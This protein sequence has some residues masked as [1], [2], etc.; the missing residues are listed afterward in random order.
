MKIERRGKA[1]LAECGAKAISAAIFGNDVHVLDWLIRKEGKHFHA[2]DSTGKTLMH[3]AACF[4]AVNTMKW[5]AIQDAQ[6]R[7]DTKDHDGNT[8]MHLAARHDAPNAMKWLKAQRAL[9]YEKNRDGLTPMH[10][11]AAGNALNALE[12]LRAW[13]N[14]IFAPDFRGHRPMH[15][16]AMNDAVNALNLLHAWADNMVVRKAG[17]IHWTTGSDI[18]MTM[19][20][21][22]EQSLMHMAAKGNAINAMEWLKEHGAGPG[23]MNARDLDENTPL[24]IAAM[25]NAAINNIVHQNGKSTHAMEWLNRYGAEMNARNFKGETPLDCARTFNSADAVEWLEQ[26]GAESG[27]Q[28]PDHRNN[29]DISLSRF[30]SETQYSVRV[31]MMA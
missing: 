17:E 14:N 2:Q 31:P 6:I 29:R 1:L 18:D 20:D 15:H 13:G 5:L 19:V 8:P 26:N 21:D 25:N 11:A 22:R 30:Q 23:A 4:N 27:T 16:A 3:L 7:V 24:H 28:D 12:W 10:M 9:T